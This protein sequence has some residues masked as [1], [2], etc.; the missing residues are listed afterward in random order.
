MPLPLSLVLALAEACAP[1]AA[2]QTL[3]SIAQVE[4]RFE[5]LAIG[6]N[7]APRTTV[8]ASTAGEAADKAKALIQA[9]RSVDLG[10]AQIN[11][12]NLGWLGLSVEAAFDPCAN[13][14]AAARVLQAGYAPSSA[15]P[16]AAQ[17]ALKVALSRYNTGDAR[18]GFANGYVAK[19][20]RAAAAIAAAP[21]GEPPAAAV[22]ALPPA[23][24]PPAW[25]VFGQAGDGAGFLIRVRSPSEGAI[26]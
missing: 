25:D 23:A 10:L 1:Q 26:P 16:E 24:P 14:A 12:A 7:G 18:R 19:V 13:L 5:P 22:A 17:A 2:P 20:S 3:A 9:G 8:A 4:S 21:V 11:S 15:A 6:V